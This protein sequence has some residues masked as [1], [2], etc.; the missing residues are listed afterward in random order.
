MSETA[1][2]ADCHLHAH[3]PQRFPYSHD[4]GS[5]IEIDDLAASREGLFPTLAANGVSH[6]LIIQPGAYGTDNRAMLEAIAGSQGRAKGIAVLDYKARDEDFSDLKDQGVV[7]VRLSLI[8]S[9][10]ETLDQ[11]EFGAFLGRCRSHGFY[12]QVFAAAAV[13]P[14]L[15]PTLI[16]SGVDV[17]VEHIGWPVIPAGIEQPGFQALLQYGRA[18]NAVMKI[19]GGFRLTQMGAPY[20]DVAPFVAEA[21][22]AFGPDRCIWGSDWPFL[23]PQNGPVIR[24]YPW[25]V[26]YSTELLSLTSWVPDAAQRRTILWETPARLFGFTQIGAVV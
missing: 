2:I 14:K 21:V 22:A 3:W 24:S 7:G 13:W 16:E 26:D 11:A 10:L 1:P 19:S 6:T 25:K 12:A 23:N 20:A 8:R 15:L 18:S 4:G 5:R 17:I 9:G